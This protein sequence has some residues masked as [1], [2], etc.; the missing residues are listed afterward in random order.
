MTLKQNPFQLHAVT[1][2]RAKDLSGRALSLD[3]A[4]NGVDQPGR[5]VDRTRLENNVQHVAPVCRGAADIGYRALV[6]LGDPC[7]GG[8]SGPQATPRQF[9]AMTRVRL[10]ME[11][12]L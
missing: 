1:A 7:P 11:H 6:D 8:L 10:R 9:P 3:L 2:N 5:I 12:L 4:Q